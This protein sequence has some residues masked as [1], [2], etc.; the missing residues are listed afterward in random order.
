MISALPVFNHIIKNMLEQMI[1]VKDFRVLLI[2]VWKSNSF[3]QTLVGLSYL[4]CTWIIWK[5]I[6]NTYLWNTFQEMLMFWWSPKQNLKSHLRKNLTFKFGIM[7]EEDVKKNKIFETKEQREHW[8]S[9]NVLK[10]N[11]NFF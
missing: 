5:I 4:T 3:K 11:A 2:R 6:L 10:D 7:S 8:H 1:S 9:N